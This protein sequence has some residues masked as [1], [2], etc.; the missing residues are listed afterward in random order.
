MYLWVSK[1]LGIAFPILGIFCIYSSIKYNKKLTQLKDNPQTE[2][3]KSNKNTQNLNEE[4]SADSKEEHIY[5]QVNDCEQQL[6]QLKDK[7][8]AR[9]EE[10]HIS[11][12]LNLSTYDRQLE[13]TIEIIKTSKNPD[14]VISRFEFL[15]D[16]YSRMSN[17]ADSISNW[18]EINTCIQELIINKNKYINESI[19]RNLEAELIK[20]NQLKTEK[21]KINRLNRFFE[22]MRTIPNLTDKNFTYIDELKGKTLEIFEN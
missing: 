21:G 9:F 1:H 5:E 20:I 17:A 7:L 16:L 4:L 13:E 3:T 2:S 14:T 22:S 18:D 12:K 6:K 8:S 19:K 10:E 11:D 15:E